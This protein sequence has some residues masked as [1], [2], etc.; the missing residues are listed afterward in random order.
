MK[1]GPHS[2]YGALFVGPYGA[3]LLVFLV[4]PFVN[5]ALLSVY[6]H[7]PT[8]IAVAEFT[9]TNYAKLWEVYYATLFLR[10]LRLS[11]VVTVVCAVL[12]YPVAY[13]LARSTSRIMTV[14]LFLLIMPLLVSTVIRVFGW[15][16]ILGSEGLVNQGLRLLGARESVRL[17]YTEGAVIIGLAQQTMPF[18]VLPIMAAIERISPSL[19]EAA[20]NLGANWGQMFVRTILPLSMPGLVSG[21]LLVFSVSMSAFVT[22]ALMGGRRE[23][24]VGQQIYEEVLTAYNWPGAASLTIVL[25]V[26]MLGLVCLALWATGR[27]ARLEISR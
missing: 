17:L 3:Y 21:S 8:K 24:M 11:L 2:P 22:P 1:R 6:L 13:F 14:G 16:V 27:R 5:V 26:L 10:T 7:S 23:R 4:L 20:R 25:S 15:L 19:E 12:G 9:A 18:M